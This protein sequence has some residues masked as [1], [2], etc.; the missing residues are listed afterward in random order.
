F[1]TQDPYEGDWRTP[2]SLHHYLYAYANPTVY[3]DLFG[4]QAVDPA[5]KEAMSPAERNAYGL[6]P[7][8]IAGAPAGF[9][10]AEICI[11]GT[12]VCGVVFVPTPSMPSAPFA[13]LGD[14]LADKFGKSSKAESVPATVK[15]PS[16]K[17]ENDYQAELGRRYFAKKI[18]EDIA[19]ERAKRALAPRIVNEGGD[20][21]LET[22]PVITGTPIKSPKWGVG[23]RWN[24]G[25][26]RNPT[27][28]HDRP[29]EEKDKE[30]GFHVNPGDR[31][32]TKVVNGT[33]IELH[34]GLN[35]IAK[36]RPAAFKRWKPGDAI[37]KPLRDGAEPDWDTVRS[38][39]WKNRYKEVTDKETLEFSEINMKR[40]RQ[41]NAPQ[42]YNIYTGKWESRELHH[43]DPQRNNGSNGPR[44]LREVT[45]DQHRKID[46]YRR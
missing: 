29:I 45:P 26:E 4:Y 39:Y 21:R 10:P 12:G 40:M 42:D 14:W 2:L 17:T 18:E 41:G 23:V 35:V 13:E 25:N 24:P 38:R 37:D 28:V 36:E 7:R 22:S 3:V 9:M 16:I 19:A 20:G 1:I 30:A 15:Q 44:N 8:S 34:P 6:A 11:P 32:D 31:P 33:P 46:P 43:V 5:V 27:L